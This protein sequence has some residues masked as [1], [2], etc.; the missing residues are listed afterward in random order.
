M[1]PARTHIRIILKA[2]QP[3]KDLYLLI[4]LKLLL[5]IWKKNYFIPL[6]VLYI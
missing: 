3:V 4:L 5:N 6:N 2:L 1:I